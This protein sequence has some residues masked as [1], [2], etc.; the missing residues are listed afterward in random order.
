MTFLA[1]WFNR[2][3]W[4]DLIIGLPY[5]WLILF[6]L[7]PF[8]IVMAISLA[9]RTPTAPPSALAGKI[10]GSTPRAI[11]ALPPTASTSAPS[12]PR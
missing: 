6:F 4:R 8:L 10:P 3:G 12:S 5:L 2:R 9:T 7:M 11:A 1:R